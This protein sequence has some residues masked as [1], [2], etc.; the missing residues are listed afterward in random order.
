MLDE[1]RDHTDCW[2]RDIHVQWFRECW[3]VYAK[4][5]RQTSGPR[6]RSNGDSRRTDSALLGVEANIVVP[7]LD[8]VDP[9]LPEKPNAGILSQSFNRLISE[10]GIDSAFICAELSSND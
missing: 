4:L 3:N 7:A 6:A 9:L 10:L 5:F 1:M 2:F 8:I